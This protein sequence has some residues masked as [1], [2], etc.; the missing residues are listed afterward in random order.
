MGSYQL[1]Y[2]YICTIYPLG[3][4]LMYFNEI[5]HNSNTPSQ[6]SKLFYLIEVSRE[7]VKP[8]GNSLKAAH[9]RLGNFADTPLVVRAANTKG[10]A[11]RLVFATAASAVWEGSSEIVALSTEFLPRES[12]QHFIL[13]VALFCQPKTCPRGLEGLTFTLFLSVRPLEVSIRS[14]TAPCRHFTRPLP[15]GAQT[16]HFLLST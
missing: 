15:S 10:L 1:S 13:P 11:G 12:I 14:L 8:R 4:S 5:F 2:I 7:M 6:S 3:N 16:F 9:A